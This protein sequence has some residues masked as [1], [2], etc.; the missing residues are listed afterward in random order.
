LVAD[1][2]YE[3]D[4]SRAR[5]LVAEVVAGIGAVDGQRRRRLDVD[6]LD[7]DAE[8]LRRYDE[9]AA[10]LERERRRL[11]RNEVDLVN[12]LDRVADLVALE[13]VEGHEPLRGGCRRREERERGERA[14]R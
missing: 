14:C 10:M 1:A 4:L 6:L 11:L 13:M 5:D 2:L 12:A 3:I 8:E 9:L 7:V